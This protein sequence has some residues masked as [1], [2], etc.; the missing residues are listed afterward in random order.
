MCFPNSFPPISTTFQWTHRNDQSTAIKQ[1]TVN[2]NLRLCI[3]KTIDTRAKPCTALA[4]VSRPELAETWTK[5]IILGSRKILFHDHC[6][7]LALHSQSCEAVMTSADLPHVSLSSHKE[8]SFSSWRKSWVLARAS[9]FV[10]HSCTAKSTANQ[11]YAVQ[12]VSCKAS[13]LNSIH[14]HSVPPSD[15]TPR[16]EKPE[17]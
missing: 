1:K 2:T 15:S 6:G 13:G 8:W 14:C 17:G 7:R 5:T 4:T 16:K 9:G 11:V 10:W 3:G 12:A